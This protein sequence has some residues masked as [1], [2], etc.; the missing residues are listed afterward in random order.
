MALSTSYI[1]LHAGKCI[2]CLVKVKNRQY[3]GAPRYGSVQLDI[4]R[5]RA[6]I[7]LFII[8]N[9]PIMRFLAILRS[10]DFRLLSLN[11][12]V[13]SEKLYLY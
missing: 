6:F 2:K 5:V 7:I 4:S 10:E 3:I 12:T 11:D 1:Q 8:I 13:S 9:I